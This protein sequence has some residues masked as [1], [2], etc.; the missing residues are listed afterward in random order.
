MKKNKT[1]NRTKNKVNPDR[2][3]QT[4]EEYFT[5]VLSKPDLKNL[6]LTNIAI[7]KAERMAINEIARC[8]PTDV[9]HQKSKQTRLLRF[10][11][12]QLPLD[13]MMFSWARFALE[14]ICG[15]NDE[16]IIILIDGVNLMY[17]YKAFVAAIPFRKRA[18]S[19]AFKVYTNQQIKDMV[20]LSEN[21]IVWNFMDMVIETIKEIM[22]D[23]KVVFVFDRGFADEKLMKYMDYFDSD[24][25]IRVPKN[26]GILGLEYKG[27]LS[28]YGHWGYFKDM[29]YHIRERIK[30]N[31]LCAENPSDAEDPYFVVSS[32]DDILGL[33][34]RKR[35]QIEEAFR[36]L[37]SL[38]GFKEL[39]LRDTDQVRFETIFLLVIISMGMIF[40]LYE[41][42]GYRWSKYYNTSSRK[43]YSLIRVIKEKLRDSWTNL[44][45][46]PLFTLDNVCFY[47]V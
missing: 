38:Y 3:I 27:K 2:I 43:E 22:P 47:E 20:Y 8:L 11:D 10:I 41:K 26:S 34:Y 35:M 9:K 18:I 23:R 7:T 33:L 46:D 44:R 24:Y 5:D 40:I 19:I 14:S 16:A 31:L 32:I 39:V 6:G 1:K 12:N 28:S 30:V 17:D 45:L 4:T 42:S 29:Y 21:Y 37:K 36:D 13:G 15:K 25:I